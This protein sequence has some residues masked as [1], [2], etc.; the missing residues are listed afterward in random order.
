M[1]SS[2]IFRLTC[3]REDLVVSSQEKHLYSLLNKIFSIERRWSFF[4]TMQQFL[5][6]ALLPTAINMAKTDTTE[7]VTIKISVGDLLVSTPRYV[8][9]WVL[10]PFHAKNVAQTERVLSLFEPKLCSVHFKPDQ[11]RLSLRAKNHI[12]RD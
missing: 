3:A 2:N 5:R 11:G 9:L 12:I 1:F 10:P 8:F 6:A 4:L 7:I